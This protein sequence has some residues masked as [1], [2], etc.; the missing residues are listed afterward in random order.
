[1]PLATANRKANKIT[2]IVEFHVRFTTL[3]GG[4]AARCHEDQK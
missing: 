2:A 4:P 1:M 3:W